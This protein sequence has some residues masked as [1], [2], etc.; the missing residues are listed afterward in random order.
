MILNSFIHVLI[1]WQSVGEVD[2]DD[3]APQ[4][5]E[6]T[7]D[8][9][10]RSLELNNDLD[11]SNSPQSPSGSKSL[12]ATTTQIVTDDIK[13]HH[14]KK[15]KPKHRWRTEH[16]KTFHWIQYDSDSKEASCKYAKCNMYV[17]NPSP[18]TC[19]KWRYPD[20]QSR[21]FLQH[22]KTALYQNQCRKILLKGQKALQLPLASDLSDDTIWCRI[23]CAW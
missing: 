11:E 14:L 18:L 16:F 9:T 22:E 1:I 2:L 12:E 19:S 8:I 15:P 13:R 7:F 17:L 6:S 20:L 4:R 10:V 3:N 23:Q 21:L 5:Q